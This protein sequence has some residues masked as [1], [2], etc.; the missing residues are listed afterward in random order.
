MSLLLR[1]DEVVSKGL[2]INYRFLGV[3]GMVAGFV[4]IKVVVCGLSENS[5]LYNAIQNM[6]S[7]Q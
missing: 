5:G 7:R 1:A 6:V 4:D 2:A 3:S